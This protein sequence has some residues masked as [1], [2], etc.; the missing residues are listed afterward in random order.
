MKEL[1]YNYLKTAGYLNE[2]DFDTAYNEIEVQDK[3]VIL[4]G[5]KLGL[6]LMADYILEIALSVEDFTHIHLDNDN[7]FD[8][9]NSEL[10]IA[11]SKLD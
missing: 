3:S 9:S 2:S 6:I 11:K 8:K 1:I 7:F 5:N 10:V 4:K